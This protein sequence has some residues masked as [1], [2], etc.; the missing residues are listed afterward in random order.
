MNY[1]LL[2]PRSTDWPQFQVIFEEAYS[3]IDDRLMA[4]ML[5]Q[6]LWDRGE[7]SGYAQHLTTD[8]YPGIDSKTVLLIEAFGDHQVANVSTE[9]LAR[10]IG[11]RVHSPV[12]RDNRSLSSIPFWGI[13]PIIDYADDSSKLVVWDYGTPPPPVGPRPPIGAEFGKDPHGAGSDEPRVLIQALNF[14]LEGTLTDVCAG[15]CVGTQ[16]DQQ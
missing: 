10:T 16:I 12:L 14:L 6:L 1:S 7:N 2:L 11:A 13:E 4:L 15:P 8:T 3:N 5:V 9:M